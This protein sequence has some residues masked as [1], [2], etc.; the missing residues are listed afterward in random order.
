M[1]SDLTNI[2]QSTSNDCNLTGVVVWS[3]AVSLLVLDSLPP[4]TVT[5]LM[6][7]GLGAFGATVTVS[8]MSG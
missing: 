2:D 8:V 6:T 5:V 1:T 3:L 4:D 7:V